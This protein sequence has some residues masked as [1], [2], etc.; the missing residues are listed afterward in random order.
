M[1]TTT[2]QKST[3]TVLE[4][5]SSEPSDSDPHGASS[6]DGEPAD[7]INSAGNGTVSDLNQNATDPD[8][9]D[10]KMVAIIIAAVICILGIVV[11]IV[12][13]C[14]RKRRSAP[15]YLGGH[16]SSSL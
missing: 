15:T 4:K 9:K 13:L 6:D 1:G 3:T 2:T 16:T 10:W 7:N 8:S 5:T 12:C 11:V 14:L